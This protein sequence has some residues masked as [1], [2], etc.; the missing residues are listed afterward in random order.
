MTCTLLVLPGCSKK[1]GCTDPISINFDQEAEEDD[2][3]CS[4]AGTGG[5]VTIAAFPKHHNMPMSSDSNYVDSA[6]VKFNATNSLGSNASAY[7]LIVPGEPGEDHV[8]IEGLKTG[9]YFIFMTGFDTLISQRV[10]GGI[11][12]VITQSSGEIDLVVP[13]TE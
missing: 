9:K 1:K 4:Y 8:H 12:D 7:D 13:I 11:P 2:G 5:N 6:F 3:S 10:S